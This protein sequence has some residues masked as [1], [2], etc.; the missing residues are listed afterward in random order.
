MCHSSPRGITVDHV[1]TA[2]A[3]GAGSSFMSAPTVSV[4]T[5]GYYHYNISDVTG[6]G[7]LTSSQTG[8]QVSDLQKAPTNRGVRL[9]IN[10]GGGKTNHNIYADGTAPNYFAGQIQ[11]SLGTAAAPSISYLSDPDTGT[12]SPAANTWAV[13]TGGVE[14]LRVGAT[15][16]V[17]VASGGRI[18]FDTTA[19]MRTSAGSFLISHDGASQMLFRVGGQD[20]LILDPA[21]HRVRAKIGFVTEVGSAAAPAYSFFGADTEGMFRVAGGSLGFSTAGTER[22]RVKSTGG[23]KYVP[24]ATAPTTP[25]EGEVYFDSTTKKLRV[26]NG[27]AWADLH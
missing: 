5:W 26:Y 11:A 19:S 27:T 4:S 22:L 6:A 25:E 7:V 2:A 9:R 10:S 16:D 13:S 17:V 14:R 12:F 21:N 18:N 15:G 20:D 24:L 8:L 23:V 3:D 1:L